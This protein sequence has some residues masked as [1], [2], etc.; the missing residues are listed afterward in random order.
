MDFKKWGSTLLRHLHL[1]S[2]FWRKGIHFSFSQI[3]HLGQR[4][5]TKLLQISCRALCVSVWKHLFELKRSD[6]SLECWGSQ[7]A[8]CSASRTAAK[9]QTNTSNS[10]IKLVR[11]AEPGERL[12]QKIETILL[13]QIVSGVQRTVYRHGRLPS[14]DATGRTSIYFGRSNWRSG[15]PVGGSGDWWGERREAGK[16]VFYFHLRRIHHHDQ[17]EVH[18]SKDSPVFPLPSPCSLPPPTSVS[19]EASA[20]L[21]HH[22]K[23]RSELMCKPDS[24]VLRCYSLLRF[25]PLLTLLLHCGEELGLCLIYRWPIGVISHSAARLVR[26]EA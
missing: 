21:R 12:G 14:A 25:F 20:S 15:P 5:E 18:H 19:A 26:G 6:P 2:C 17:E 22:N 10:K 4:F 13:Q 11:I 7:P 16:D 24:P 3:S 8:A 1:C 9:C 23:K